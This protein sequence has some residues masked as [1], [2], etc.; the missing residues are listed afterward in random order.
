MQIPETILQAA[1]RATMVTVA[2]TEFRQ[3]D[4][5]RPYLNDVAAAALGKTG[6]DEE[7]RA[8]FAEMAERGK[9]PGVPRTPHP[10]C[11][12][13]LE[14]AVV[15]VKEVLRTLKSPHARDLFKTDFERAILEALAET[16]LN[17]WLIE[18]RKHGH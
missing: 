8:W 7:A 13:A 6:Q 5:P 18:W 17:D 15:D 4:I 9:W 3:N 16:P 10:P 2:G 11:P 12:Q 14:Q 1:A